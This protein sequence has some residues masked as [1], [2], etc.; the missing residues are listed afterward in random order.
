MH[1]GYGPTF[2]DD[3]GAV[4]DRSRYTSNDAGGHSEH[5]PVHAC[6]ELGI[7]SSRNGYGLPAEAHGT[8]YNQHLASSDLTPL[9]PA[10]TDHADLG[11]G[12]RRIAG[13]SIAA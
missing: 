5:V 8:E 2:A 1:R 10:Q 7:C 6:I 3:R 11:E 12:R 9:S 13:L 4:H